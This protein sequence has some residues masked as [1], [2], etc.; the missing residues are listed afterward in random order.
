[1]NTTKSSMRLLEWKENSAALTISSGI[2]TELNMLSRAYRLLFL[3]TLEV[4]TIGIILATFPH[5]MHTERKMRLDSELSQDSLLWANGKLTGA[6]ATISQHVTTFSEIKMM[7][8]MFSTILLIMTLT[9]LLQRTSPWRSFFL[10][11]PPTLRYYLF[12]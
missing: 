2:I 6:R 9:L 7:E 5:Q 4:F 3:V 11:V 10:R 1:M 8:D 12:N